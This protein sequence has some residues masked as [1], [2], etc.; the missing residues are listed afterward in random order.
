M[1]SSQRSDRKPWFR[2]STSSLIRR[3]DRRIGDHKRFAH[4]SSPALRDRRAAQTL[5][6]SSPE[7][8]DQWR[9]YHSIESLRR[10]NPLPPDRHT[11]QRLRRSRN[12]VGPTPGRRRR[13]H[14]KCHHPCSSNLANLHNSL[15]KYH[16]GLGNRSHRHH[17]AKNHQSHNRHC[18]QAYSLCHSTRRMV[19]TGC[20]RRRSLPTPSGQGKMRW[21]APVRAP[22]REAKPPGNVFRTTRHSKG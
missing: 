22:H 14:P 8:P 3:E 12:I 13:S 21:S 2:H 5:A 1:G 9:E 15:P 6:G 10:G 17:S 19:D 16:P 4:R 20:P 11:G 7:W 18:Y